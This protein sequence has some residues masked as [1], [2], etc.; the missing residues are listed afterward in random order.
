MIVIGSFKFLVLTWSN[1]AFFFFCHLPENIWQLVYLV[2]KV[3]KW[4][5]WL[6]NTRFPKCSVLMP[7]PLRKYSRICSYPTIH[8]IPIIIG[9]TGWFPE[10]DGG[11][12]MCHKVF[13][14]EPYQAVQIEGTHTSRAALLLRI[15]HH[16]MS[17][18][19][20]FLW[21]RIRFRLYCIFP[22]TLTPP[23]ASSL[24]PCTWL[25]LTLS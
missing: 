17:T 1:T 13:T 6:Q 20:Y 15:K 7:F 14:I 22:I 2:A 9:Q 10:V 8:F 18:S 25:L 24:A 23:Y 19:S 11:S 5:V 16:F 21:C 12:K 4:A 3:S